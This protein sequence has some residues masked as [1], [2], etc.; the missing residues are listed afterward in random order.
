MEW[1]VF[2]PSDIDEIV[3]LIK[4]AKEKIEDIRRRRETISQHACK[5]FSIERLAEA[6]LKVIENV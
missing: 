1:Q 4:Q 2:N 3:R 5:E 6:F